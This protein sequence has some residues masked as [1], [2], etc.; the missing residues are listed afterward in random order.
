MKAIFPLLLLL[1]FSI[2]TFGQ[3]RIVKKYESVELQ[4]IRTINIL[5]PKAYELD[6][7]TNYPLTIVLDSEYLFDLYVGNSTMLGPK[8]GFKHTYALKIGES[9]RKK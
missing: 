4:D 5:L 8:V 2:A 7:I 9:S 6:T 1:F 3:K